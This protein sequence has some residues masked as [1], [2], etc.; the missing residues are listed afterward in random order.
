MGAAFFTGSFVLPRML[1]FSF[2]E[3]VCFTCCFS[4]LPS[5][6]FSL[7]L[8]P[9]PP[10][11]SFFFSFPFLHF[12]YLFS[13]YLLIGRQ[14]CPNIDD[15]FYHHTTPYSYTSTPSGSYDF[16]RECDSRLNHSYIQML[17]AQCF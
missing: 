5:S 11:P 8:L 1:W 6:S 13:S 17:R 2:P 12:I 14:N 16:L 3:K 9:H 7:P 4:L 10:S 15:R